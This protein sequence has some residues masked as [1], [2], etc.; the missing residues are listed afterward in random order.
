MA[1]ARFDGIDFCSRVRPHHGD[2]PYVLDPDFYRVVPLPWYR[3][4]AHLCLFSPVL[5]PRTTR[6]LAP[7]LG[8]W[9]LAVA[10]GLHPITPLAL[11]L[12]R[13]RRIPSALW[14]RGDLAS[15]LR[16][17]LSGPALMVAL[18]TLR[19]LTAALP[20]GVPVISVGRLIPPIR[21]ALAV[22]SFALNGSVA[23][24]FGP[25]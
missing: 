2:A 15:D 4:V 1:R 24:M 6:R 12:A 22:V 23:F 8:D 21:S 13:K 14:I 17:R 19:A 7:V 9:G 18:A 5:L 3:S 10:S 25:P 16:H 11:R 20:R